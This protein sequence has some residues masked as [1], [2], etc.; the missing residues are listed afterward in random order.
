GLGP[1]L[2]QGRQGQAQRAQAAHAQPFTPRQAV[3]EP[4]PVVVQAEHGSILARPEGAVR[5]QRSLIDGGRSSKKK[6]PRGCS[7]SER[8]ESGWIFGGI[9]QTR[10]G[11]SKSTPSGGEAGTVPPS[12]P[13]HRPKPNAS[14]TSCARPPTPTSATGPPCSPP[15]PRANGS[16]PPH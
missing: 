11:R 10:G 2:Q 7:P 9:D 6:C 5:H 16:A 1:R 4:R 15:K 13:N 12:P 8:L 14:T 3:A